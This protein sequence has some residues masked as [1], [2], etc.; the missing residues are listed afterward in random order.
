MSSK[1]KLIK[2]CIIDPLQVRG[3]QERVV[4]DLLNGLDSKIFDIHFCTSLNKQELTSSLPTNVTIKYIDMNSKISL[5][6]IYKFYKYFKSNKFDL[7]NPHGTRSGLIARIAAIFS[8]TKIIWTMHVLTAD[9]ASR[10]HSIKKTTYLLVD[11]ILNA[12]TNKII[13]VANAMKIEL[14]KSENINPNKIDVVYNGIDQKAITSKKNANSFDLINE[15]EIN[16]RIIIGTISILKE[17]K[18]IHILIQAFKKLIENFEEDTVHLIIVGDGPQK[19]KLQNMVAENYLKSKITFT[20]YQTDIYNYLKIM[21]VFVLPSFYEGFPISLLEAML[22]GKITIATAVNGVPEL[23]ED[24][25]SGFL[26]TPGDSIKLSKIL[27]KICERKQ[28]YE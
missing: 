12:Y 15:L 7:I 21:D 22:L 6:S 23:I 25:K 26:F 2:I 19:S 4:F 10:Y 11:K 27:Y 16:N 28:S 20:G 17:Q 3:G 8:G 14:I 18:G 13:T 1:D 24:K 5:L 9:F